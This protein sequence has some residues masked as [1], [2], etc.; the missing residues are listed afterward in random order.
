[1][2][3]KPVVVQMHDFTEQFES[4]VF[5]DCRAKCGDR[6][7]RTSEI[8][9]EE[10][11]LE[12]VDWALRYIYSYNL[13]HIDELV[14]DDPNGMKLQAY[15]RY[16]PLYV[17]LIIWV[18]KASAAA[19]SAAYITATGP[20]LLIFSALLLRAQRDKYPSTRIS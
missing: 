10:E 13:S 17:S 20:S 12:Q 9:F 19:S 2:V 3:T 8:V 6:E 11:E 1:M 5:S 16:L 4:G 18:W 15:K 7:S 14:T